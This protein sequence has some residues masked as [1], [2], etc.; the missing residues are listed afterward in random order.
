MRPLS[1]VM[2]LACLITLIS[3]AQTKSA[4]A[5][6]TYELYSWKDRSGEWSFSML[7]TTSR[8]KTPKEIFDEKVTIR[9]MTRLKQRISRLASKSTIVC[10]GQLVEGTERLE[11]PPKKI[12]DEI[13]KAAN[14]RNIRL[15]TP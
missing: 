13:R 4:Q 15:V 8:L 10:L 2:L 9:G 12:I 3:V 5:P 7:P 1:L 6:F 14:A 11:L